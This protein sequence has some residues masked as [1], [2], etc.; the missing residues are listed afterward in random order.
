M[1]QP[2]PDVPDSVRSDPVIN[3]TLA[4]H[5][6]LFKI[7]T[8]I[9]IDAFAA[10]LSDHPN[11]PFVLSVFKGL[12]EGFWPFADAK[13]PD[14][15]DTWDEF[16]VPPADE[17]AREFLRS[18]RD[19][20]IRLERF[21]PS[22]GPD[23]LPGMY[24]MP[25]HVVPK[26][27][28]DKFRLVN[29]QSAG[30][31]SL[32]SLIRPEA[33]H[34][35]VL[36]GMPALGA[37]LRSLRREHPDEPLI[38]W[39][40]DVSQA[41]RRLPVSIYWQVFHYVDDNSGPE[42]RSN[43]E[44]YGP[45]SKFLPQAQARLL[46]LWDDIKLPHEEPKQ[47]AGV[48]LTIIGFLVD[49]DALTITIP[50]DARQR[51][52]QEIE[53]FADASNNNRRRSLA[54]F[55]AFAGYVNWA[56]NV[57]PL[58]K[59]ALANCYA[60]TAGKTN[61]HAGIFLNA[62]IMRDMQWLSR[63]AA[64][65]PP[66]SL[67]RS[68]AWTPADLVQGL[69]S[70]EFALVDA[71]GTGLGLYFPWL[72][73]GFH[74]LRPGSAPSG[75]IFFFEALAVCSA[76]HRVHGWQRA[77]RRVTRLAVLSDNTNTV[78]LFNSLRALPAYNHILYS[79]VDVLLDSDLQLRVDRIPG[80]LN[81]VAD[82]LSRGLFDVARSCDPLIKLSRQPFREPWSKERLILERATA[83]EHALDRSTHSSYSSALNSY[84]AFC[85]RQNFS[86]EPTPDTLSLYV[87]FQSHH[88]EPR[89][90]DAY[91]SGICSELE[92][93]YPE[94]R[95][96]RRSPLVARTLKGCKRLYSKPVRRKRALTR[97]DLNLVVSSLSHSDAYDD[98]LFLSLLLTGFHALLRLGELV[99]PDQRD[100]RSY[101]KLSRRTTV[102]ISPDSFEFTLHSHKTDRQF[103]G[104]TVLVHK[105]VSGADPYSAFTTFLAARDARHP[106]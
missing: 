62:A 96:N 5:P 52:L 24:S 56:N 51:L 18:Q 99:W 97:D 21:S 63:R 46:H 29:D 20:E 8:P 58:L 88:I 61:R 103:A 3:A 80:K 1:H 65:A 49:A 84:L 19:E 93:F 76:V 73:W 60:K 6:E 57:M 55:R 26:P 48:Q 22:F 35:A 39:K 27:H 74:C 47:V 87:T 64:A 16:R 100:L 83:L 28:S 102:T 92:P 54:Q 41:Y 98:R 2:L 15:P 95:T 50:D 70:D 69:V 7:V 25:V 68:L 66:V 105:T 44:W 53:S 81:V 38:L 33:I 106:C 90:V 4:A 43:V 34:G 23:L 104:D 32:N 10:L 11:Q 42:L 67:L 89:S 85:Q 77:N 30:N 94:V 36:D 45:Y 82:T 59:P 31:F 75:A 86:L 17:A 13:P 79:T 37:D 72:H 71:S 101:S 12:R 40:S 78:S 14:Y 9:D 91:L